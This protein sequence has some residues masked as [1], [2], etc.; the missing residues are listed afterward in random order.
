MRLSK[1]DRIFFAPIPD[2]VNLPENRLSTKTE[3]LKEI[4]RRCLLI[5]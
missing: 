1:R 3:S 2:S 4:R 5:R